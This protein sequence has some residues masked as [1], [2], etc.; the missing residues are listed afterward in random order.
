M[1]TDKFGPVDEDAFRK[2][3]QDFDKDTKIKIVET[4]LPKERSKA[5][6]F[7]ASVR[8][9]VAI[10]SMFGDPFISTSQMNLILD[11]KSNE[12]K[13]DFLANTIDKELEYRKAPAEA[14][15]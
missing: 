10:P 3:V 13:I 14:K 12:W 8:M 4:K 1:I 15:I 2:W 5:G 7:I 9:E 6:Y 11:E